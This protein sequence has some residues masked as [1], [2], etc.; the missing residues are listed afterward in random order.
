MVITRDEL[1]V[2]TTNGNISPQTGILLPLDDG[3]GRFNGAY[4]VIQAFATDLDGSIDHVDFFA[5]G[6][7]VGTVTSPP[8]TFAFTNASPGIYNTY[9]VAYDNHGASRNPRPSGS[10]TAS[11]IW[12]TSGRRSP[13]AP[14]PA[15]RGPM[16]SMAITGPP[17]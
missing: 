12:P 7:K 3:S 17:G 15:T 4:P 16:L 5:N 14:S 2:I 9:A 1:P 8:Y 6:V 11:P 10:V 13:A